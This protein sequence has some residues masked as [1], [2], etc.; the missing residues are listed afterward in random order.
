MNTLLEIKRK[1]HVSVQGKLILV[2]AQALL[3]LEF[4]LVE[5]VR[6]PARDGHKVHDLLIDGDL[7]MKS[8]ISF[9]PNQ[10]VSTLKYIFHEG[11]VR[12]HVGHPAHPG[13]L[14]VLLVRV[15]NGKLLRHC[16]LGHVE[17]LL[18]W[19]VGTSVTPLA[20]HGWVAREVVLNHLPNHRVS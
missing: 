16:G 7:K 6:N 13:V 8:V 1:S 2:L 4:V 10:E 17:E 15:Q 11:H 20:V 3:R 9:R 19:G 5:P 12:H 18:V 14:P